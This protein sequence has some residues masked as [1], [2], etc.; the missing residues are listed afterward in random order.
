M[1]ALIIICALIIVGCGSSY[2]GVRGGIVPTLQ[3]GE[4]TGSVQ[5]SS[6]G[7]GFTYGVSAGLSITEKLGL[8]T[9]PSIR[10]ASLTQEVGYP[11]TSSG[12]SY[13]VQAEATAVATILECPLLLTTKKRI[14]EQFR[15]MFGFG[16][17]FSFRVSTTGDVVGTATIT[18]GAQTGLTAP[19]QSVSVSAGSDDSILFGITLMGACD[20]V[21]SEP[22][23]LRGEVRFQHDFVNDQM[24]AY[25]FGGS[26]GPYITAEYPPTR[27]SIGI[28]VLFST[29]SK[30]GP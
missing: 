8:Q 3:G 13:F 6:N 7:L 16:P 5:S 25:S 30:Q 2:V 1:N 28:A 29:E 22:V 15:A 27:L 9:D 12:T 17:N 11:T 26:S 18:D 23:S 14:N 19:I 4:E 24:S 10:T 21:V 20:F